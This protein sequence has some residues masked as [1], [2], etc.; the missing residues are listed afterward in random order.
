MAKITIDFVSDVACP[1]CAVGLGGLLEAMRRLEGTADVE[2]HFR[3]F[4]LNPDMPAG[5]QNTIERLMAK[6]GYDRERVQA[7]RKVISE[8]AAAVG[9]P[10]RMDDDNRSF[11]T[12]D[13]HRLIHWAGLQGQ[14][15]QIALKK[16][17]LQTYHYQNRDTSDAGV[18]A[19]AVRDAGL[20]EAAARDVLATGRYTDEVRA[21][22]DEWRKLGITSVPSVIINGEYLVSGGQPPDTFEQALRQVASESKP[23]AG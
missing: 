22:E 17:L 11:N 16:S 23:V 9:M 2:L 10:M 12:F 1:W 5:G 20:D 21:E 8:R 18:L 15:Q 6:Y 7:N 13:A 19:E 4:E 3:P 14:A